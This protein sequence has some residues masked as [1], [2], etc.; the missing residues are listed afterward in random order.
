M[1]ASALVNAQRW[2]QEQGQR[3]QCR[4]IQDCSEQ[5]AVT[6]QGTGTLRMAPIRAEHVPGGPRGLQAHRDRR[7]GRAGHVGDLGEL[8]STAKVSSPFSVLV[9][10]GRQ[11]KQSSTWCRVAGKEA[12]SPNPGAH[13]PREQGADVFASVRWALGSSWLLPVFP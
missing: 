3:E 5:M 1:P 10:R 2:D 6:H 7:R 11:E 8:R 12:G 9:P 13:P 4:P